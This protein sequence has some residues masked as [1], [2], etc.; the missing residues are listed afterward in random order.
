MEATVIHKNTMLTIPEKGKQ[1][2]GWN[3]VMEVTKIITIQSVIMIAITNI[4]NPSDLETLIP[5]ANPW[6]F[7][8]KRG[9]RLSL[10]FL[11]QE[12]QSSVRFSNHLQHRQNDIY[13]E[14]HWLSC[15]IIPTVELLDC[16]WAY[17]WIPAKY[18]EKY[19]SGWSTAAKIPRW[20]V[21]ENS[22]IIWVILQSSPR[23]WTCHL[24]RCCK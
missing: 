21:V 14:I 1:K 10:K 6:L 4:L 16:N 15:M 20:V 18:L 8:A 17:R 22:H 2:Y 3:E 7:L 11:N 24:C 23:V 9:N 12:W 13:T 19:A 5:S